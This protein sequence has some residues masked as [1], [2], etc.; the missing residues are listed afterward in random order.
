MLVPQAVEVAMNFEKNTLDESA[1]RVRSHNLPTDVDILI[2]SVKASYDTTCREKLQTLRVAREG[3]AAR[4]ESQMRLSNQGQ[5]NMEMQQGTMQ[6]GVPNGRPGQFQKGYANAQLQQSMQAS[7][8]SIQQ[9]QM[10]NFQQ[11][12]PHS[13]GNNSLGPQTQIHPSQRPSN[14]PVNQPQPM[15]NSAGNPVLSTQEIHQVMM[16]AQQLRQSCS[17]NELQEISKKLSS[18]AN[19]ATKKD[20]ERQGADPITM[21]FRQLAM[22]KYQ[23]QKRAQLH[24]MQTTMSG[25]HT[26]PQQPLSM[27][28][29]PSSSGAQQFGGMTVVQG[30]DNTFGGSIQQLGSQILGLQQDGIRSQEEGQVVVPASGT[31]QTPQ[32]QSQGMVQP[33]QQQQS[34]LNQSNSARSM[35]NHPQFM[36][37][38]EKLQQVQRLQ[39]QGRIQNAGG[40]QNH[41][42]QQNNLQGQAGGLN[43]PVNQAL[44]QQSPA[45]PNLNRPLGP[46]PQPPQ[47]HVGSINQHNQQQQQLQAQGVSLDAGL[48][49]TDQ[50]QAHQLNI[51]QLPLPMQQRLST[52]PPDEQRVVIMKLI[53]KNMNAQNRDVKGRTQPNGMGIPGQDVRLR[54]PQP[55]QGH[56]FLQRIPGQTP[57]VPNAEQFGLS[58]SQQQ[59]MST[60]PM[61]GQQNAQGQGVG[62]KI[63]GP[64]QPPMPPSRVAQGGVKPLSEDQIRYMDQQ[65]FPSNILSSNVMIP[66]QSVHLWGEL[67]HWVAQNI[68]TMPRDILDKLKNLQALVFHSMVQK[69]AQNQQLAIQQ[70]FMSQN[71]QSSMPMSQAGPAPQVSMLQ[72]RTSQPSVQNPAATAFAIQQN[73]SRQPSAQDLQNIRDMNPQ[74]SKMTDDQ[75]R[76]GIMRRKMDRI[77]MQRQNM[78]PQQAQIENIQRAQFQQFQRQTTLGANQNNQ[79]PP[80]QQAALGQQSISQGAHATTPSMVQAAVQDAPHAQVSRS[81]TRPGNQHPQGNKGTKR[82]NEDEV[83][84]VSNHKTPQR[85]QQLQQPQP[86][87]AQ[88]PS[89]QTPV[90]Q[91]PTPTRGSRETPSSTSQPQPQPQSQQ[92]QQSSQY[93]LE[94]RKQAAQTTS[95]NPSQQ[96]PSGSRGNLGPGTPQPTDEQQTMMRKRYHQMVNEVR[97]SLSMRKEVPMDKKTREQMATVLKEQKI[98][99]H[100]AESMELPLYLLVKDEGKAKDLIRAVSFRSYT[101]TT[102]TDMPSV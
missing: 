87:K 99:I 89:K 17:P 39:A 2:I 76:Q 32:Q 60:V 56:Q 86:R 5:M 82:S 62:Q 97:Q 48:V 43:N 31:Q 3:Q 50:S 90:Q 28:Q 68:N 70:G 14:Q 42:G 15:G 91:K 41:I 6:P 4:L 58:V 74:Y 93:E 23:I 81:S 20:W 47:Q 101:F 54:Q 19:D 8:I 29:N 55:P 67:K 24:Q 9:Q 94:L 64:N 77:N 46:S 27:P 26:A 59:D 12:Q 30:F 69:S 25:M 33:G 36:V 80:H 16:L 75:L 1:D 83:I 22:K 57:N 71:M 52:M 65:P 21:Y 51:S 18:T 53:Q 92:Q 38:Q 85:H 40:M 7:P 44:P 37:Q 49:S 45:M 10:Q 88:P 73:L 96:L 98:P 63:L 84:E 78:N 11:Q 72:S 34:S 102:V 95:V 66:P 100:R 61:P 79:G 35:V 13:V